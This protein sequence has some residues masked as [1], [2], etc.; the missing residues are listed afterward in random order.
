MRR[1]EEE[2]ELISLGDYVKCPQCGRIARVVWISPDGEGAGVQCLGSHSQLM[3]GPSRFG[4]SARPQTK[5][6]VNMVFLIKAELVQTVS[7]A[8]R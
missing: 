7:S 8:Q 2:L 1:S 5:S 3:R 4:S 6:Q